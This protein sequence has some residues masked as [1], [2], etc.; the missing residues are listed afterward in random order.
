[1]KKE[2][3]NTTVLPKY[4]CSN[5]KH[6][7]SEN[8]IIKDFGKGLLNKKYEPYAK[9]CNNLVHP[10]EDCVL[11]GFKAHS[12]QPSFSQT[13]NKEL[14]EQVKIVEQ[15]LWYHFTNTDGEFNIP[16]GMPFMKEFLNEIDKL[17]TLSKRN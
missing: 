11:R 6:F 17:V 1:M 4:N 2:L 15:R 3:L 14:Q 9:E 7:V 16:E 13:L 5:C 8:K 10:L 12:E